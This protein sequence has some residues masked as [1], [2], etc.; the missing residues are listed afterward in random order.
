MARKRDDEGRKVLKFTPGDTHDNGNDELKRLLNEGLP[1][2]EDKD[3]KPRRTRKTAKKQPETSTIQNI[4]G[5]GNKVA[6]GSINEIHYHNHSRKTT[7]EKIY[8]PPDSIGGNAML[9]KS[10]QDR[11]KKLAD[12]RME[13]WGYDPKK[14]YSIIYTQFKKAFRMPV[15]STFTEIWRWPTGCANTILDY[16]DE[17][18]ANTIPGKIEESASRP[19]YI[20][21]RP[22]LYRLEGELLSNI[23]LQISSPEV[24]EMLQYYFGK[25]SHRSLTDLEHWIFVKY[26]DEVV[27]KKIGE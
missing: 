13:H 3:S 8:P 12:A 16:L 14:T 7:K 10:I 11:I 2:K 26:L 21:T 17:K 4:T 18:Y 5:N 27:K 24:K 6:G 25:Q 22:H 19:G 20:H 1:P 15:K 23:G 9:K